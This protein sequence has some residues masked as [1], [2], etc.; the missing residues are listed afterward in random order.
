MRKKYLWTILLPWAMLC[1][2][3]LDILCIS[4]RRSVPV[5]IFT[6]S[7]LLFLL[8]SCATTSPVDEPVRAV[9]HAL[10]NEYYAKA[11]LALEKGNLYDTFLNILKSVERNP[12]NE[13]AHLLLD[14]LQDSLLSESHFMK[15]P[16]TRGR[17]MDYPLSYL[18]FYKPEREA[19]PVSDIPVKFRFV[20]GTGVLTQGAVTNDA[21]IAKCY[22]EQI[23]SFDQSIIIE[24]VPVIEYNGNSITLEH[25]AQTYVFSTV[26][27]LE[28]TQHVYV[29]LQNP[30]QEW[31]GEQFSHLRSSLS[32]LFRENEFLDVQFH[33]MTEEILFNRAT[34]LDRASI[35][36]LTDADTLFLI[37]VETTFL[38]QQSVDFFFSNAHIF[39]EVIDTSAPAVT[40]SDEVVRRGAGKT[41]EMSAYQ[42]VVN[43]V[44]DLAR[45]LDLYLTEMRSIHGV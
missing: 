39:L 32:R 8:I 24:A 10:S 13:K 12:E 21:G 11:E 35:D 28:Q 25:L 26:S 16:I 23:E 44:K 5:S 1:T 31:G 27:M 34:T 17:G 42:A 19:L 6:A 22:V 9:N 15:E 30:D 4:M 18:L 3:L 40:F 38:S 33:Y 37:R 2:N 36:I 20:E 14:R 45:N 43:A 29:F 41:K 7:F